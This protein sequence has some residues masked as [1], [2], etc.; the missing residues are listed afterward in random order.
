MTSRLKTKVVT[1]IDDWKLKLIDLSRRNKLINYRATKSSSL[2]I[3][4]SSIDSIFKR[5]VNNGKAWEIWNPVNTSIKRRRRT[6]LATSHEDPKQIDRI[7]RNLS[8]RSLSEYRERGVRILYITFGILSWKDQVSNQN[9]RS[10][11]ILV[12]IEITKKTS[13]DPFK[14]HIPSVEEEVS[15]NPALKL[16]LHYDHQIELP[17][18]PDFET[19]KVSEYLHNVEE[20]LSGIECEIELGVNIG[21]FSFQKLVMYQDLNDNREIIAEHPIIRA[22]SGEKYSPKSG[23]VYP[24][25]E[26]LDEIDPKN[27]FQVLDADSSQQL[28]IQYALNGQSFVMHGP[29]GTGKSQTISNLISEFIARGKSVLFVSEKMAALEVVYN[30]LKAKNLEEYCLELHSH[31]ANKREVVWE[32][33]RCLT[34]HLGEGTALTD[35]E[36]DRLMKRRDQ[37]NHYVKSL[38]ET[39]SKVNL[40]TFQIL[41]SLSKHE[42]TPFVPT[43]FPYFKSLDQSKLLELEDEVRRLSNTWIVVEE[44][45]S[46]PWIGCTE[47]NF[48][49]E[50]RSNWIHLLENTMKILDTMIDDSYEYSQ[51]LGLPFPHTI[52]DYEHLQ[53]LSNIISGSP[54]PPQKWFEKVNLEELITQSEVH[55]KEWEKYRTTIRSLRTKYDSRFLVLPTGLVGSLERTLDL[56]C[57]WLQVELEDDTELYMKRGQ[58]KRYLDSLPSI[59]QESW[60]IATEISEILGIKKEVKTSDWIAKLSTLSN[61]CL[62]NIR[63]P[64]GWLEKNTSKKIKQ[65]LEEHKDKQTQR[66][67]LEAKL[68]HYKE[69]YLSIDQNELLEYFEGQGKSVVRFFNPKYYRY[70]R[71]ISRLTKDNKFPAS[72]IEDLK[73]ALE[74]INLKN[75]IASSWDNSRKILGPYYNDEGEIEGAEK[76]LKT[77]TQV[78][79][80]IG[81]SRVPKA[82]RDNLCY[83]TKP[84][85]GLV[86]SSEKLKALLSSLRKESNQLKKVLPKTLPNTGK[87]QRKST[88]IETQNWA[89]EASERLAD[90]DIAGTTA[91]VAV[92]DN[93]KL[94][95]W[96][97]VNDLKTVNELQKFEDKVHENSSKFAETYGVL[98][99]GL[100]TNWDNV[101]NAIGWTIRLIRT[102]PNGVSTSLKQAVSQ[103]G[104]SL[105]TD[106]MINERWDQITSNLRGL[107]EKFDPPLWSNPKETLDIDELRSSLQLFRSRID[108]LQYWVDFKHLVKKLETEGL[109]E[110]IKKLISGNTARQSIVPIFQKAM[111]QGILERVYDEDPILRKFRGK[112]HDQLIRD[113]RRLDQRFIQ[114]TPHRVIENVNKQKPQGVFVQSPDSEITIL[115]REAAKKRRHMPLRDLFERIPNLIRLLKP[116]LMMSPISV[117]QFL[118][119]GGLEFD[120]VVFDEAS[121]IYTEDAIGSIYRGN[122]FIVT[123]DPKQLPPTPFFQYIISDDFDWDEEFYGFDLFDSVLDECMAIGLPVQMLKWHYRSKHESLISFSNDRYYDG[124]LTIFP[125][126]Q[127]DRGTLGVEFVYVPDG[128]YN[129][130]SSRDNPIE[131]QVVTDLVFNQFEKH[132]DKT[133]GVV[134]FSIAQMNQIQDSIDQRLKDRPDFEKHFTEDRLNGFFVKNLENVQGD[135][136]DVMI[137]SVGYGYDNDGRMTMNFGPLNKLGGERRLN[138]AITRAKEKVLLVSSIRHDDIVLNNTKAEGVHSLYHYLRHTEKL[139]NKLDPGKTSEWLSSDLER[140]VASEVEKMGYKVI[141]RVGS[142]SFRVD[143]GVTTPEDADCFILGIMVDGDNYRAARTT[144]D[145]DRLRTQVLE[146]NGWRIHKIWSP[147]WVQRRSSEV[148]RLKTAI[149]NAEQKPEINTNYQIAQKKPRTVSKNKVQE[150][151]SNKLPEIEPYSIAKLKPKRFFNLSSIKKKDQYLKQYRSEVRRLIPTLVKIEA[152]IHTEYAYKRINKFLHIRGSAALKEAYRDEIKKLTAKKIRSKGA[153]LH[154][155]NNDNVL[156]RAPVEDNPEIRRQIQYIPFDEIYEAML[157]VAKHSMGLS[158]KFLISET[159]SLLGFKK[160]GSKIMQSLSNVY[161]KA[162]ESGKL[163]CDDGQVKYKK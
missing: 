104:G 90:L 128:V 50:T 22:L 53:T 163:E 15:L 63:P 86:D 4:N 62:G 93:S 43:G 13:R 65:L 161:Q 35:E 55:R 83:D 105:P 56:I 48:T 155:T 69:G 153:F 99:N 134:T 126:S 125:A 95:Y 158:E 100:G 46:F 137:F 20:T 21:L 115:M 151:P 77:A 111:F 25:E 150:R 121:Q 59:L 67:I 60:T 71:L 68:I 37:L 135:E 11:L 136:R 19:T 113:F 74:L 120:L 72:I 44:G 116:C 2:Q 143:L 54:R 133:V 146:N 10:P 147:D 52:R 24:R 78:I 66:E 3:T 160:V 108:D 132:P 101:K 91:Y 117:S 1:R 85:K 80:I 7:L 97:L 159:A 6:Q 17:H 118:I 96:E 57:E 26:E 130:G 75:E 8:R 162:V 148:K 142:G 119:P 32:L 34:E 103:G 102:L 106:P 79:K 129:R 123:G 12:P 29:P 127:T 84:S 89:K 82:L 88:L 41:S 45:E 49:P 23:M 28:C 14:I 156:V 92:L 58:L 27:T 145:R 47:E 110:F 141:P 5:L 39:R 114:F 112:D 73:T 157:L 98:Y 154:R 94:T 144:R 36:L 42:E 31:K 64:R 61:L 87:P 9:V 38:H 109:S 140:E 51:Q 70:T 18:L 138:V 152:P 30:R 16:K 33:N 124:R 107:K 81:K 122:Q 149:E 139:I 131:A 76:A 40:T